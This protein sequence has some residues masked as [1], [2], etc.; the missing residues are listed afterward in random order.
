MS[1]LVTIHRESFI[2]ISLIGTVALCV[3]TGLGSSVRVP[4]MDRHGMKAIRKLEGIHIGAEA[5]MLP[6][7]SCATSTAFMW[8]YTYHVL[9]CNLVSYSYFNEPSRLFSL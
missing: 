2:H 5:C 8:F 4:N 3:N 7:C 1:I 9:M 6:F